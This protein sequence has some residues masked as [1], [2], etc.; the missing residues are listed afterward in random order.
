LLDCEV[1]F[2]Q[3]NLSLTIFHFALDVVVGLSSTLLAKHA[4][5]AVGG[6]V[7]SGA[8]SSADFAGSV[9]VFDHDGNMIEGATVQR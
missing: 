4:L 1:F 9:H 3:L 8:V 7:P 2:L 6:K 5:L